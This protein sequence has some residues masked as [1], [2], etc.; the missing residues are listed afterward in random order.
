MRDV[1][2]LLREPVVVLLGLVARGER[3]VELVQVRDA[4][5]GAETREDEHDGEVENVAQR[6]VEPARPVLAAHHGK[7]CFYGRSAGV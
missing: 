3:D 6:G 7:S 4:Q 1:K 2:D 5:A